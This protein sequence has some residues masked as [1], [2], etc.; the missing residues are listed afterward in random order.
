MNDAM[1]LIDGEC[2]HIL[3][4][5]CR[6]LLALPD[7]EGFVRMYRTFDK[8]FINEM[9][10]EYYL[11]LEQVRKIIPFPEWFLKKYY[12]QYHFEFFENHGYTNDN[13]NS[14]CVLTDV[15]KEWKTSDGRTIK[16]VHP[17]R[18]TI[19]MEYGS[20]SSGVT[21]SFDASAFILSIEKYNK[22]IK[23]NNWTN[24]TLIESSK[25]EVIEPEIISKKIEPVCVK[26]PMETS[27]I[28]LIDNKKYNE[29]LRELNKK[30]QGLQIN[31]IRF[32]LKNIK[33]N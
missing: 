18:M 30:L 2:Y 21:T 25:T 15:S 6:E 22:T 9:K 27:K 7:Y 28:N 14:V 4:K 31:M 33:Q 17:S 10:S 12:G 20:D 13:I 5:L 23:Q 1:F 29:F 11:Y 16:S 19:A 26:P 8:N 3:E 24:L 32:D